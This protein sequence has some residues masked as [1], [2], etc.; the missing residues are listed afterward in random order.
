MTNLPPSAE[1]TID[2][3]GRTIWKVGTL[4]YTLGGLVLLCSLL[5]WGDFASSMKER[6][7]SPVFQT[8]LVKY[9][10]T[11]LEFTIIGSILGAAINIVMAPIIAY[12]SDRLRSRWGRRI[13]FL[14]L[15]APFVSLSMIGVALAPVIGTQIH[16]ALGPNAPSLNNV[17]LCTFTFFWVIYDFVSII[18]GA[19]FGGL[20][21]DI[22][23]RAVLGRFFGLWRAVS[24][25]CGMIFNHYLM[26]FAK[27]HYFEIFFG[28]ALLF[29][30][31]FSFMCLCVKEGEY[32]PPPPAAPHGALGF[33]YAAK[34]YIVE[35]FT[36]P[37]YWLYFAATIC[38]GLAAVPVNT[39]SIP[40]NDQIGATLQQYGDYLTFTFF[41]SLCLAYPLGFLVDRTHPLPLGLISLFLYFLATLWGGFYAVDQRMYGIAL[42]AHGILSGTHGTVTSSLG[43]RLLPKASF[44]QFAAAGGII[45]NIVGISVSLSIGKFLDHIHHIYRYTYFMS[46]FFAALGCILYV[47]LYFKFMKLGGPQGYIAPDKV[48]EPVELDQTA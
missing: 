34:G 19:V 30:F 21:N 1:P 10:A 25:V 26:T 11:D 3:S 38:A 45:G 46:S 7:V 4:T 35:C 8:L 18:G 13:P 43:Q 33:F 32:P 14:L 28:M 9:G 48:P 22:V 44:A 15:S 41:I 36:I 24:L 39:F 27:T 29:G 6:S 16:E 17:V 31:G 42:V 2:A 20:I 40:F 23:P 12:K 37:Y 47:V 5:L